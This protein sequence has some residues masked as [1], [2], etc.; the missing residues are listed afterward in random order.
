MFDIIFQI[1]FGVFIVGF[2]I[3]MLSFLLIVLLSYRYKQT[4]CCESGFDCDK[5]TSEKCLFLRL[6]N[7]KNRKSDHE[8]FLDDNEKGVL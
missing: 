6:Y 3:L 8:K 2:L 7:W 1:L 4:I 5:C